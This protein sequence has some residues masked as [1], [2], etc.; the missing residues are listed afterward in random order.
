MVA[1]WNRLLEIAREAT[2]GWGANTGG[3]RK[4][5]VQVLPVF[6]AP[7]RKDALSQLQE[8]W[9]GGPPPDRARILSPFFDPPEGPSQPAERIWDVLKKRGAVSVQF[10]V[11]ADEDR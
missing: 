10:D 1:R 3:A 4:P 11:R 2:V 6:T 8:L 7:G 9:P 5:A